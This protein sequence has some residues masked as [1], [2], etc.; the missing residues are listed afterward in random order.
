MTQF[1]RDRR[2]FALEASLV[3][4]VLIAALIG[5]AVL[6]SMM[7]QRSAGVDYRAA[8]VNYAAEAGADNAMAQLEV[9]MSDGII[10]TAEL[11]ALTSPTLTGFTITTTGTPNGGPVPATITSG[12]YTGLIG[13][14]QKIDITV[15]ATDALRNRSDAVV[16]VNAQS[17]PLFQF[18]VFYE[19]DL[20]IHNGPPMTFAG[21]VHTNSNLY[22]SASPTNYQDIITTP[23]QVIWNKKWGNQRLGPININNASAVPVA[24]SFD[25]RS[26]GAG[27]GAASQASFNGRLM[28]STMGVV[29]LSLPLPTGMPTIELIMPR[30][31]PAIDS[32]PIQAVK[33][34]WKA[35]YHIVVDLNLLATPC[36]PGAMTV[37]PRAAVP[38]AAQCALIFQGRPNA[39]LDG[40]EDRRPDL[41]DVNV[42]ELMN[43]I[44]LSPA[45][46]TSIMYVT[47]INAN[48]GVPTTDYP[49]VRLYNARILTQPWTIATDRPVYVWKNYNDIGWQP[50]AIM[51]DAVTFLSNDWVDAAHTNWPAINNVNPMWVYAA[52]AAG[53]SSTPCDW[54]NPGCPGGSYGGGLENFPRFLE[55]WGGAGGRQMHYRGSLVS[56]FDAQYANLHLWNWRNYYN[57][58]NRDWQFDTR[59]RNPAQLPP[60]TP[61]A[62]NVTQIS[63]RPVY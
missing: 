33:M 23:H 20:E 40:R 3:L 57:P 17:I 51:G 45:N 36:A 6:G 5:A 26:A 58:P 30:R 63:F 2:G 18:G 43:W 4:L 41:L 25:S 15:S 13:I 29:P 8:R 9:S 27:F 56:M 60:G 61:T 35:D 53:H 49:A 7:V 34:A 37:L 28:D 59:F 19:G 46:S 10:T 50:S 21:W 24:L 54:F 31:N 12:P 22:L 47:F 52:I 39:F 1:L 14:N 32:A 44:N 38:N 42:G 55:N 62:G 16:G 11:A 48:A